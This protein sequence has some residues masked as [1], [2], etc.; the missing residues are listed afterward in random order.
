MSHGE[1]DSILWG[2]PSSHART[3]PASCPDYCWGEAAFWGVHWGK[4][5]K[6]HSIVNIKKKKKIGV[7]EILHPFKKA[8]IIILC[9]HREGETWGTLVANPR[10]SQLL[11]GSLQISNASLNDSGQYTCTVS[12]SKITI[13]AELDVLSEFHML[14]YSCILDFISCY[15]FHFR[16]LGSLLLLMFTLVNAFLC[17]IILIQGTNRKN[18]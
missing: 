3:A 6:S 12:N 15:R 7:L 4:W 2:V 11:D 18:E 5:I 10:M 1:T 14:E 13:T 17:S 9:V 8:K 16:L